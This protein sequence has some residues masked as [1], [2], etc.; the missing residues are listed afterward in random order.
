MKQQ[1]PSV[2]KTLTFLNPHAEDSF[3]Q[4]YA[5]LTITKARVGFFM[6]ALS[7][8]VVSG[9]QMLN[10]KAGS[11]QP[12]I[13]F[14]LAVFAAAALAAS[15][16]ESLDDKREL[17]F[18]A[19][20]AAIALVTTAL[21]NMAGLGT[22]AMVAFLAIVLVWNSQLSGLRFKRAAAI[23]VAVLALHSVLSLASMSQATAVIWLLAIVLVAIALA[24]A[25]AVAYFNESL[26]RQT[27]LQLEQGTVPVASPAGSKNAPSVGKNEGDFATTLQELTIELSS[28]HDKDLMFN[29]LVSFMGNIIPNDA[30]AVGLVKNNGIKAIV[31]SGALMGHQA[32]GIRN[33]LWDSQ[34]V[35]ELSRST[36]PLVKATNTGMVDGILVRRSKNFGFR[37][38]VPMYSQNRL[39]GS[40][41][42]LRQ[43][44]SFNEYETKIASSCVFNAMMALK[45][46]RLQQKMASQTAV[47]QAEATNQGASSVA[48]SPSAVPLSSAPLTHK[49]FREKANPLFD[50]VIK[51][52]K[53]V[54]FLVVEIDQLKIIYEK[55]GAK[56]AQNVYA[57]VARSLRNAIGHHDLLGYYGKTG[58]AVMLVDKDILETQAIAKEVDK[59]LKSQRLRTSEGKVEVTLSM[60]ISTFTEEAQ[61]FMAILRSAD[62]ALF[63]VRE[64]GG[65]GIRVNL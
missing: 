30:A 9:L 59:K 35:K 31:T 46:A 26:A 19:I 28:I 53:G 4:F 1:L 27:F 42:I 18:T 23:G 14:V 49:L 8:L 47:S 38:D 22:Q 2:P 10:P 21:I 62:M 5:D 6:L 36:N 41:A 52:G 25:T 15:Y 65:N 29:K 58:F 11:F 33:T 48:P 45:T 64:T 50:K 20:A 54:S 51:Q 7:L 44:Q 13:Y 40:L 34:T 56:I 17:I 55:L 43:E 37:L 61:D 12:V 63:M 57:L 60:G 39:V 16:V 32:E 3:T 24:V